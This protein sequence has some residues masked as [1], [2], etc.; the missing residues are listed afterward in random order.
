MAA[1]GYGNAGPGRGCSGVISPPRM[2][3]IDVEDAPI[4]KRP[5]PAASRVLPSRSPLRYAGDTDLLRMMIRISRYAPP[6]RKEG[7]T[8]QV[9]LN[10]EPGTDVA[11]FMNLSMGSTR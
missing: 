9:G 4:M 6:P 7:T 5:A 1:S 11:S 3:H 8:E 10:G 2:A